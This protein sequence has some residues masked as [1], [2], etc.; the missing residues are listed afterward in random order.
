MNLYVGTSGY[1]YKPWKETFYP[2][3]LPDRQ[4]LRFYAEHFRA[5][6]INSTFYRM[7][8]SSTLEKWLGEVPVHFKFVLKAPQRITHIHRLNDI[9]VPVSYLLDNA[10]VLKSSLGPFLFQLPPN[11]KKDAE[12]LRDL[13]DLLPPRSAAVEF[14]HGSWF[15]DEIF[16][17][18]SEHGA[19]LCIADDE[20][21]LEVP[22]VATTDWG[23]L[24]LR[25]TDYDDDQLNDWTKRVRQQNWKE[26]FCFF[27]HEDEGKGP[28]FAGRFLKFAEEGGL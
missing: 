12:R 3:T 14:R 5:V 25:R 18:L 24:R 1:A 7:P 9:A 20:T 15:D 22:L 27:K 26:L 8:T 28:Q 17:L 21:A 10:S 11:L 4:M 23:Y 16:S 19:A 13:L 6:E 2:Q